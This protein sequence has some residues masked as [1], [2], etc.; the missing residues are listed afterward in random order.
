MIDAAE[1]LGLDCNGARMISSSSRMIWYLPRSGSAL[2]LTR[3]ATKTSE[4]VASEAAA[5]RAAVGAGVHTPRLIAGPIGL[6]E[7]RHAMACEWVAGRPPAAEDWP[8]IVAESARLATASPEGLPELRWPPDVPD[9]RSLPVL[10]QR[11]AS[12]FVS[13][14][15]EASGALGSLVRSGGVVLSHGDLQP[16]NVLVDVDDHAWLIDL[17]Y[18]CLA[19]RE[20]DPAK[21][22]ILSRRFADPPDVDQLLPAWGDLDAARLEQ[23][24]AAQEVL[25]VGWLCRM[26]AQGTVGAG[27]EA[28]RRAASLTDPR[29]RWRHL[30]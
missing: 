28:R 30:R 26:A 25:L 29:S 10:G 6:P 14:C 19:P 21:L 23:C 18:A 15:R 22:L 1:R 20:W 4:G 3:P 12:D 24:V 11:L 17:E 13:R 8:G 16:G 27:E 9:A 7:H 2:V 5:I